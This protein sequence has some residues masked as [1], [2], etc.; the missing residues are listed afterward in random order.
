MR[1]V[2]VSNA[3]QIKQLCRILHSEKHVDKI[4]LNEHHKPTVFQKKS[5]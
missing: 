3:F 5:F 1:L 2:S 4:L